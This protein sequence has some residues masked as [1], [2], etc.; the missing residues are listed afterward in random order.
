MIGERAALLLGLFG[1]PVAL[2]W[3]GHRLRDRSPRQRGA[4]WGGA[5]GHTAA[6]AL[7]LIVALTP[8]IWW[9]EG[10][11][12]RD[13]AVHWSMLIGFLAGT[14]AGLLHGGPAPAAERRALADRRASTPAHQAAARATD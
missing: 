6:I 10:G 14:G 7:T 12:W 4:F 11:F 9:H 8:P 13:F 2:L 3:L 1:A 5:A